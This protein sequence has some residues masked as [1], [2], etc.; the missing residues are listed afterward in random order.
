LSTRPGYYFAGLPIAPDLDV[1][2]CQLD[3]TLVCWRANWAQALLDCQFFA[4]HAWAR[5]GTPGGAQ[6]AIQQN[7]GPVGN[8]TNQGLVQLAIQQIEAWPNQQSSKIIACPNWQSSKTQAELS[9]AI[10]QKISTVGNRAKPQSSTSRP[11][12]VGNPANPGLAQIGN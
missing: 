8:P 11:G 12:L 9:F 3:Q 7:L 10:Q 6:L 1:L 2:D 5:L 4:G